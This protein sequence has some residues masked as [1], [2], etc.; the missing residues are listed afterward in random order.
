MPGTDTSDDVAIPRTQA[1]VDQLFNRGALSGGIQGLITGARLGGVNGAVSGA[2]A[3]AVGGLVG[4]KVG[5]KYQSFPLAL[6]AGATT[7]AVGAAALTLAM[8]VLTG[9]PLSVA[10]LAGYSIMG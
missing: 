6:A 7:G 8:G 2:V 10:N 9:Q 1:Q 3:G 4:S 5:F